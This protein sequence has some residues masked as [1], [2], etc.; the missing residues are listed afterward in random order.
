MV[1]FGIL[2]GGTIVKEVI[3]KLEVALNQGLYG[4]EEEMRLALLCVLANKSLFLYGHDDV[5]EIHARLEALFGE[6]RIAIKVGNNIKKKDKIHHY[7]ISC[8]LGNHNNNGHLYEYLFAQNSSN[9]IEKLSQF[10]AEAQKIKKFFQDYNFTQFWSDEN[11]TKAI[12]FIESLVSHVNPTGDL[13]NAMAT[14]SENQSIGKQLQKLSDKR[15]KDFLHLL[16]I[17]LIINDRS[18][19]TTIDFGMFYYFLSDWM[20]GMKYLEETICSNL[21]NDNLPTFAF[22][23]EDYE[24]KCKND[25]FVQYQKYALLIPNLEY[26]FYVPYSSSPNE[27]QHDMFIKLKDFYRQYQNLVIVDNNNDEMQEDLLELSAKEEIF[28]KVQLE[29]LELKETQLAQVQLKRSMFKSIKDGLEEKL[30]IALSKENEFKEQREALENK[31]KDTKIQE[32]REGMEEQIADIKANEDKFR[33]VR[34]KLEGELQDAKNTLEDKLKQ[35]KEIL[36]KKLIEVK[37]KE[38]EFKIVQNRVNNKIASQKSSMNARLKE[39]KEYLTQLRSIPVSLN[40]AIEACEKQSNAVLKP[41]PVWVNPLR[42]HLLGLRKIQ[43]N[44]PNMI[45]VLDSQIKKYEEHAKK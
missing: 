35:T 13:V 33:E 14:D 20:D 28:K 44:L 22:H 37:A 5:R 34:I 8:N 29:E 12:D 11:K 40:K 7:T 24:Q 41:N 26:M 32:H 6:T 18:N 9:V 16:A 10:K 1:L 21:S 25:F 30:K 45:R 4:R 23:N 36:E 38:D 19:I 27:P 43:K 31:F 17:N 42:V 39:A 2:C 3:E 15:F